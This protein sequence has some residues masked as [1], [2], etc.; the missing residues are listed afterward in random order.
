LRRLT[1][2]NRISFGTFYA[3]GLAVKSNLPE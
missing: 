2:E 1:H 3:H